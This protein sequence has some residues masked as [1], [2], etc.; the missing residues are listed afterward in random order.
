MNK[1]KIGDILW[2]ETL[3]DLILIVD[4]EDLQEEDPVDW[5]DKVCKFVSILKYYIL[6]FP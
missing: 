2:Y 5:G 1:F 4:I 3:E 6:Y